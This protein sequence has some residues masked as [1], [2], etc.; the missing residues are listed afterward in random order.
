MTDFSRGNGMYPV[1]NFYSRFHKLLP[2]ATDPLPNNFLHCSSR[3]SY[4]SIN[5]FFGGG[6]HLRLYWGGFCSAV[7]NS[8]SKYFAWD[9]IHPPPLAVLDG[10]AEALL[11]YSLSLYIWVLA[12]AIEESTTLKKTPPC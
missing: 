7:R 8:V 12:C 10:I 11:L 1:G 5:F 4:S 9:P 3:S 6:I 2:H